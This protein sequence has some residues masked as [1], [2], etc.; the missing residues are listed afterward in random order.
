MKPKLKSAWKPVSISAS[1]D[2]GRTIW[3]ITWTKVS[4]KKER[5]PESVSRAC[6]K[7]SLTAYARKFARRPCKRPEGPGRY[8]VTAKPGKRRQGAKAAQGGAL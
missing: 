3:I 4:R 7:K 8:K 5:K 2:G 6:S 1:P